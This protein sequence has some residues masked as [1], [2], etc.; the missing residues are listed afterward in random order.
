[1]Q[2][3]NPP[4]GP[5]CNSSETS[6]REIKSLIS[7]YHLIHYL[8]RLDIKNSLLQDLDLQFV[9]VF[10]E[11]HSAHTLYYN[12]LTKKYS[13]NYLPWPSRTYYY[14]TSLNHSKRRSR[15]VDKTSKWNYFFLKCSDSSLNGSIL[16]TQTFEQFIKRQL[17][18]GERVIK[19]L[20]SGNIW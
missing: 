2:Y 18:E 15:F 9:Q 10:L 17:E 7:T 4:L 5:Y 19:V 3:I 11:Q 6:S 12:K 13:I 16:Q 14:L 1:M 8:L 20:Q